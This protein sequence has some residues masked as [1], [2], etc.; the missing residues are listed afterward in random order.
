M[1]HWLFQFGTKGA[2]QETSK[3]VVLYP[4]ESNERFYFHTSD[5]HM[6]NTRLFRH[7]P[8]VLNNGRFEWGKF[9]CLQLKFFCLQFSFFAYSPLRCFL[10][11]YVPTVSKKLNC[12]IVSKEAPIVSKEAPKHNCKQK[13]SAVSRKLPIVSK[14]PHPFLNSNAKPPFL[15]IVLNN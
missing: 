11:I 10:D 9:F 15:D 4:Q 1:K 3:F 12:T 8:N 5:Q 14:K 6:S 2:K 7:K 13:S